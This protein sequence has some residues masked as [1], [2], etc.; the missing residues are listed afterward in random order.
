[1]ITKKATSEIHI[2]KAGEQYITLFKTKIIIMIPLALI[3]ILL[4]LSL[5]VLAVRQ[6]TVKKADNS[7]ITYMSVYIET[8][9]TL[10]SIAYKYY[11]EEFGSIEDYIKEIKKCNSL[12]SD[13]IYA[14]RHIIVPVYIRNGITPASIG[15]DDKQSFI[16]E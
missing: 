15:G 8:D 7:N 10:W 16:P 6:K 3:I 2:R 5:S 11:S 12:K 4:I 13:A 1:M 9:D 14:G